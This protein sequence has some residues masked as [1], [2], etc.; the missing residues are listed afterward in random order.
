MFKDLIKK[1]VFKFRE[2]CL[3]MCKV[4]YIKIFIKAK[5]LD[6]GFKKIE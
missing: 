3:F 5:P 2:M 1:K 4:F 6:I